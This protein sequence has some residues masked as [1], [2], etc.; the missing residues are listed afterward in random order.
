MLAALRPCMDLT[1][2]QQPI[3]CC[4]G[5]K[6]TECRVALGRLI[7]M[8]ERLGFRPLPAIDYALLC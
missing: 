7:I 1:R 4:L 8:H 2:I 5:Y 3:S 6:A